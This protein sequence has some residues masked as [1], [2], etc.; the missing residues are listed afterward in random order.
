MAVISCLDRL[1]EVGKTEGY[2]AADLMRIRQQLAVIYG[3]PR[4]PETVPCNESE[5]A[6]ALAEEDGEPITHY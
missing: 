2:A 1:I 4:H 5:L 6:Q 3:L